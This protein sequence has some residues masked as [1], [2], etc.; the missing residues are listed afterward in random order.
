VIWLVFGF[1]FGGERY[2]LERRAWKSGEVVYGDEEMGAREKGL[3]N[4]RDRE[5]N[6]RNRYT[7]PYTHS[8]AYPFTHWSGCSAMGT[9]RWKWIYRIYDLR[10]AL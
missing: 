10:S 4:K 8:H 5:T 2:R 3:R 9:V 7:D 6:M 1:W